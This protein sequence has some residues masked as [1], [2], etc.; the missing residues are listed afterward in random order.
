MV[1]WTRRVL[2]EAVME[3]LARS[4]FIDEMRDKKVKHHLV[5]EDRTLNESL[6]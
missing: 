4:V 1:G 5:G 2:G 3:K 6:S